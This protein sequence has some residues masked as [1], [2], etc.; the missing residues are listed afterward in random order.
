MKMY[1]VLQRLK[2]SPSSGLASKRRAIFTATP[3]GRGF[4]SVASDVSAHCLAREQLRLDRPRVRN[5]SDWLHLNQSAAAPFLI[6]RRARKGRIDGD[7]KKNNVFHTHYL[8]IIQQGG[9]APFLNIGQHP[10]KKN[11]GII[12]S[13]KHFFCLSKGVLHNPAI[14]A[15]YQSYRVYCLLPEQSALVRYDDEKSKHGMAPNKYWIFNMLGLLLILLLIDQM[16][17]STVFAEV[18]G[19]E[20]LELIRIL[21][22]AIKESPVRVIQQ[23]TDY[24]V[25]HL[26]EEQPAFLCQAYHARGRQYVA[27]G[28]WDKALQDYNR[29]HE[30][31]PNNA[32]ILAERG[33]AWWKKGDLDKALEDYD[34][35]LDIKD[36]LEQTLNNRGMVWQKKGDLKRAL[37]DYNAALKLNENFRAALGNRGYVLLAL[38]DLNGALRDYDRVIKPKLKPDSSNKVFLNGRGIVWYKKGEP[39]KALADFKAALKEDPTDTSIL[40]NRATISYQQGFLDDALIDYDAILTSSNKDPEC[41]KN[42]L[43]GRGHVFRDQGELESAIEDYTEALKVDQQAIFLPAL[44]SRAEVFYRENQLERSLEDYNKALDISEDDR[45]LVGRGRVWSAKNQLKKAMADYDKAIKISPKNTDALVGRAIIYARLGNLDKA[46]QDFGSALA[47]DPR[48][49]Y[50]RKAVA[51]FG[52]LKTK[53]EDLQAERQKQ[54]RIKGLF[55]WFYRKLFPPTLQISLQSIFPPNKRKNRSKRYKDLCEEQIVFSEKYQDRHELMEKIKGCDT[56]LLDDD[57][58]NQVDIE[59]TKIITYGADIVCQTPI[60]EA[61]KYWV[62]KHDQ[63]ETRYNILSTLLK[64]RCLHHACFNQKA[65][66]KLIDERVNSY[67]TEI[68]APESIITETFN[69][70]LDVEIEAANNVE[71]SYRLGRSFSSLYLDNKKSGTREKLFAHSAEVVLRGDGLKSSPCYLSISHDRK[72]NKELGWN[73]SDP[74]MLRFKT[75]YLLIMAYTRAPHMKERERKIDVLKKETVILQNLFRDTQITRMLKKLVNQEVKKKQLVTQHAKNIVRRIRQTKNKEY[76]IWSGYEGHTLFVDVIK[77][78]EEGQEKYYL[79]L[80]NLG[81]GVKRHQNEK[82]SGETKYYPCL[83]NA[84]GWSEEALETYVQQLVEI[85]STRHPRKKESLD[86][87]YA[88]VTRCVD[89]RSNDSGLDA[90]LKAYTETW[91]A[92]SKQTVP[93]CVF[94][95]YV[96]SNKSRF[97]RISSL[98]FK[99]CEDS[100]LKMA[101][102]LSEYG[103]T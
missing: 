55:F 60:N 19:D 48:L 41:L 18:R 46:R 103:L 92:D 25:R 29:A 95:S 27:C 94:K 8:P 59:Q 11:D 13:A 14:S 39:E 75:Y 16:K 24:I 72:P 6:S 31:Q 57:E 89:H 87:I 102:F 10:I 28:E 68:E 91:E 1:S 26:Q 64:K 85:R 70:S 58:V 98:F 33:L 69:D 22:P 66:N 35:A 77:Q 52:L 40:L 97:N 86:K 43:T 81:D 51:A 32:E 42:A 82:D 74:L 76:M 65:M 50:N 78:G 62:S 38:G 45:T 53:V 100:Q 54:G 30:L 99:T 21:S 20:T 37:E 36:D 17:N 67:P 56:T 34:A 47:F 83:L 96:V 61:G 80:S 88:G 5:T 23:L 44:Q 73:I 84:N 12:E 4:F 90:D 7:A 79:K 101:D 71:I 63:K 93:N 15:F 2:Q 3:Y 49:S 9:T